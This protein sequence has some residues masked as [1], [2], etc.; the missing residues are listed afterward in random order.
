MSTTIDSHKLRQ[1]FETIDQ[2]R[3]NTVRAPRVAGFG[4]TI[5]GFGGIDEGRAYAG[6][7]STLNLGAVRLV[8][9]AE[10]A[11]QV[12]RTVLDDGTVAVDVYPNADEGVSVSVSTYC[13][14]SATELARAF[15]DAGD[16]LAARLARGATVGGTFA[17]MEVAGAA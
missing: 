10:D 14:M 17:D 6:I 11:L 15:Q 7:S 1:F 2:L 16:D 4:P 8:V 5:T 13:E 12:T 9:S 3:K